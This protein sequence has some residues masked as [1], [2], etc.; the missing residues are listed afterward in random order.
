MQIN[1]PNVTNLDESIIA[2]NLPMSTSIDIS[3]FDRELTK[4]DYK[5]ARTLAEVPKGT[6]HDNFLKGIEIST[7]VRASQNWWIQFM[8]Y[9]HADIVSS[10]SKMHRIIENLNVNKYEAFD[11][12]VDRI[13]IDRLLE[14][15]NQYNV[16]H[17][18][19]RAEK[20]E[21]RNLLFKILYSCPMGYMLAA[22]VNTNYLQLKT[23]YSQRVFHVLPEW[24]QFCSM[25]RDLPLS[26]L[27]TGK[28]DL[29]ASE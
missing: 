8:R 16:F 26:H 11:D 29:E 6:G 17:A 5:R 27:I 15:V 22:R 12:N 24:T 2:S 14:L 28:T 21:K 7:I 13:I 20:I 18:V 4:S 9:S 10:Q 3:I 23:I 1:I 25:I 19:T